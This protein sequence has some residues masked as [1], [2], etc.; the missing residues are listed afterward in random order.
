MSGRGFTLAELLV[1]MALLLAVCGAVAAIA[2]PLADAFERITHASDLSG[3]S[4]MV[5]ERLAAEI[6][7]AGGGASVG[8]PAIHFSTLF[9]PL[10]A[11]ADL[12]SS[13]AG[14]P[15]R[16]LRARRAPFLG[17]QAVLRARAQAGTVLLELDPTAEC[18][19]VGVACG[20]ASGTEA[21]LQDLAGG[22][23]VS[24]RSVGDA[25]L[26]LRS[27]L[28]VT[29]EAGAVVAE[30][31]VVA[32]GLRSDGAGGLRLVREARGTEQ[33]L[34]DHVVDF[35]VRLESDAE[36]RVRY[37]AITL[38]VEVPS[39]SFRGPAGFL[40]RR[41]GTAHKPGHWVPDTE[42]RI[43]VAPRSAVVESSWSAGRS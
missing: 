37:A 21:L 17:P 29:V 9:P 40:F 20:F 31:V 15:S 39:A 38:R 32:Y 2:V 4:R 16:A 8:D 7:Q 22:A 42:T 19:A 30:V 41:A 14:L 24:V 1:A 36:H 35:E 26:W 6:R 18:M 33:P 3:G 43:V 23:M 12:D 27:P 10:E 11:L 5:L 34:L 13:T 28:P 25:Q